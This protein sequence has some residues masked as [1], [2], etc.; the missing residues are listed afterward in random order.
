MMSY[1]PIVNVLKNMDDLEPGLFAHS[2][3]VAYISELVA[4]R[5]RLNLQK[6]NRVKCAALFHDIGKL[7]LDRQILT[8]KIS[9]DDNEY[10]HIKKHPLSAISYIKEYSLPEYITK[11]VI[12]HHERID[13]RGYPYGL[14]ADDICLEAKIISVVDA[15]DAM[16]N[17]RIYRGPLSLK[18][19]LEELILNIDKQFDEKVVNVFF[20]LSKEKC[21]EG[22]IGKKNLNT[23][24][25]LE[26]T[27]Q[28][29]KV[30]ILNIREF[31]DFNSGWEGFLMISTVVGKVF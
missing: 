7:S 20:K 11:I 9:L 25:S 27:K 15:F 1:K 30:I 14:K 22:L 21:L 19:A 18:D 12:M 17:G 5:M 28:I 29:D 3:R 24:V 2:R 26:K 8:K 4:L 10:K 13:G 31:N 6:I 16:V 23:T